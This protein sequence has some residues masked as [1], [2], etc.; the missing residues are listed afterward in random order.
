M[1]RNKREAVAAGAKLLTPGED[2]KVSIS[3]VYGLQ[4]VEIG[5]SYFFRGHYLYDRNGNPLEPVLFSTKNG[6][7]LLAGTAVDTAPLF[8]RQA[9]GLSLEV[10]IGHLYNARCFAMQTSAG[11]PVIEGSLGEQTTSTLNTP[12]IVEPEDQDYFIGGGRSKG[13]VFLAVT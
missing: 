11:L 5:I 13:I 6:K 1:G 3:G 4:P 7:P 12:I 10:N 9:K 2:M 8:D